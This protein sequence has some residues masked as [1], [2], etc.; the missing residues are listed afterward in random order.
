MIGLSTP[1]TKVKCTHETVNSEQHV[2]SSQVLIGQQLQDFHI[3]MSDFIIFTEVV[4]EWQ[5]LVVKEV[6]SSD[7]LVDVVVQRRT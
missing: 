7:H 3:D 6:W 2:F 4:D 5:E 1:P